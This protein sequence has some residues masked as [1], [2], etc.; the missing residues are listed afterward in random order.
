[1]FGSV[2]KANS[3]SS[4]AVVS[5][6]RLGISGSQIVIKERIRSDI[7]AVKARG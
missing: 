3:S 2:G 1:V 6:R 4:W 7:T 5:A